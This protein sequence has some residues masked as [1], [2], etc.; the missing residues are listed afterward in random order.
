MVPKTTALDHSATTSVSYVEPL[1]I[2]NS[3]RKRCV[4]RK[5]ANSTS[6]SAERTTSC[7]PGQCEMSGEHSSTQLSMVGNHSGDWTGIDIYATTR[8]DTCIPSSGIHWSRSVCWNGWW[9]L[10]A[11]KKWASFCDEE[12]GTLTMTSYTAQDA[13]HHF[14]RRRKESCRWRVIWHKRHCHT[15][16][17][18]RQSTRTL[19]YRYAWWTLLWTKYAAKYSVSQLWTRSNTHGQ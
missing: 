10:V 3:L 7:W 1:H 11:G 9:K 6:N 17:G 15:S 12:K 19:E 13:E 2:T 5:A 18:Q 14:S 16:S 4:K 8:D